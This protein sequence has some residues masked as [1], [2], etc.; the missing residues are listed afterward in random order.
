MFSKDLDSV[1][2][3]SRGLKAGTVWVNCYNTADNAVPFGG[4]KQSGVGREK[5]EYA[6][7]HY[8]QVIG[9]L[10]CLGGED[11]AFKGVGVSRR[12]HKATHGVG[13]G[14]RRTRR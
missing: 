13:L 10:L 6:L 3:I 2:T 14:R 8:T 11:G 1:N 9:M 5:G 7:E 4:Y 12:G